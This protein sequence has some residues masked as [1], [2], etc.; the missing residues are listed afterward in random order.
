MGRKKERKIESNALFLMEDIITS[1]LLNLYNHK[2]YIRTTSD[3]TIPSIGINDSRNIIIIGS[4]TLQG[5][6]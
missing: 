3:I 5:D 1:D 2:H 4:T 6:S